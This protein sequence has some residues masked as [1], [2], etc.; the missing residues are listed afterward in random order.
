[1]GIRT[2]LELRL[3]NSPGAAASVCQLLAGERVNILAMMLD[4][5]GH[6][7]LLVDNPTRALGVLR[8]Q[9]HRVSERDVIALSAPDG[10][11]R[12]APILALVRDAGVNIDYAYS[13]GGSSAV[14]VL[15]VDD[16]LRAATA[17]GV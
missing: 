9:H 4:A 1:M 14:V 5:G 13:G 15:G 7:H 2:E 17:A 16:P 8:E 12:L 6:L 3:P 10:P 11:G